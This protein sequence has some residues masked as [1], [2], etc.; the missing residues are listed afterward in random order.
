MSSERH[1]GERRDQQETGRAL[2]NLYWKCRTPE[3][4]YTTEWIDGRWP[5]CP[6]HNGLM[7][8]SVAPLNAPTEDKGDTRRPER[9]TITS[10][11][12]LSER[13]YWAWA[14]L[15]RW[16]KTPPNAP[17]GPAGDAGQVGWMGGEFDR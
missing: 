17:K 13:L 11:R 5:E 16:P 1:L 2:R 12:R 4:K 10:R 7:R 6:Y 3:C 9:W 15:F 8:P 14:L